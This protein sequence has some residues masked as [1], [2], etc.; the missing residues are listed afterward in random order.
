[1]RAISEKRPW[2][3][4]LVF[5]LLGPFFGMLFLG[6]WRWAAVYLAGMV[7]LSFA[8][9]SILHMN[10]YALPG[11][12]LLGS[13]GLI[14]LVHGVVIAR[15]MDRAEP[16]KPGAGYAVLVVG[17]GLVVAAVGVRLFLYRSFDI[18]SSSMVPTLNQGDTF[19]V[20]L[21]AYASGKPKFGDLVV[22]WSPVKH[23]YFVKRIAGVPG[24][25]VQMKDS[26]L[27]VN[28]V[29]APRQEV[30]PFE[31]QGRKFRQF[32]EK[33]PDGGK[34]L[35]LDMIENAPGDNTDEYTVPDHHYFMMGDN[36]DNSND[37]RFQGG[38]GYV[39]EDDILGRIA[40]LYWD[41][42]AKR[43]VFRRVE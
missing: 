34:Y 7:A 8:I 26:V 18:P 35:T 17:F 23:S 30:E 33:R 15:R 6:R 38:M 13:I 2:F 10:S 32:A 3:V 11:I 20:D 12:L 28:G 14:G 1:M 22:F 16:L 4:G 21:R 36:R 40:F 9:E 25:R 29:A 43:A 19:F 27:Y 39:D 42:T 5:I 37:S 31:R 41:G 24:D